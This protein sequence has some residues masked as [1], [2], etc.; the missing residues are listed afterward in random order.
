MNNKGERVLTDDVAFQEKAPPPRVVVRAKLAELAEQHPELTA[1]EAADLFGRQLPQ[2]DRALVEAFLAS[3][4]RNMFAYELRAQFSR[5]R[6]QIFAAI[7]LPNGNPTEPL[8]ERSESVTETLYERISQWRE[9]NP[10]TGHSQVLMN[11]GRDDLLASAQYDAAHIA[12]RGH[13]M[14]LKQ[15]LA[16]GLGEGDT[17]ADKFTAE[18]IASLT[19]TIKK[20]MTRGNFRLAIKPVPALPRSSSVSRQGHGRHA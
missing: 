6:G 3:E 14:L 5:V 20:E 4:A 2:E 8:R 1:G 7:E 17:V 19:S 9:Y 13:K 12:H 18:Q 10:L 16:G 15:R 11:M